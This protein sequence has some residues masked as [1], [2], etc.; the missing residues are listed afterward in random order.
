L[1]K[2]HSF[3]LFG[4]IVPISSL[5]LFTLPLRFSHVQGQLPELIDVII[6]EGASLF[7]S[8]VGLPPDWVVEKVR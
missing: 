5:I 1:W 8:A 4:S 3:I 7:V 6:A 2:R